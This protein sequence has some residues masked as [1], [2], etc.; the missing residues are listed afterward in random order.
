M[1]WWPRRP[2]RA[3]PSSASSRSG[4]R[5]SGAARRSTPP[6][7]RRCRT[8]ST[9]TWSAATAP[10]NVGLLTG[11]SSINS[12]APVVVMTTEVLRNM[13][14]AGS[15]TLDN[16][17]FVVMDE[18]HYL[19]D[20][21][22]GAV[23]EEV[24]IGLAES[25]QLVA[26]SATVSNAEEF[27]D[28]LSEVRG[29][30]AVVVSERRPVPLFQHVLVG[31]RLYDLF[32]DEAPT[33]VALPSQANAEV[34]PALV[35][36][37]KE[38]SRHVRD[39]SRRPRGRGGKGK[40]TVALRQRRVRRRRAPVPHRGRGR[41]A[42]LAGRGLPGGPGH[43]A[44]RR[45]AAARDRV[46]LLPG[47]LRRRRRSAARL[48]TAADLGRRAGRAGRDRR[49]ARRRTVGGRPAGAGLRQVRRGAAARDRRAPRRD[50]AR[51]QGGGRGGLREGPGQ[52]GLRHRDAGPG[53]QH[54]GPQR[55][56]GEAGQVQ[57]RD[58]RRHHAGGVHPADR[59]G[60]APWHRRRGSR[61]R[62][63]AAGAG[64][65]GGGRSGLAPDVPAE[66]LV[67]ADLQ[68]GGQPGRGGRPGPG[69]V[70]AGAV[71]RP[72]PDRP[73]GGGAVPV[74]G[75]QHRGD[76]RAV[77]RGGLRPRATTRRTPGCGPR[78]APSRRRR[79]AS[80]APIAGP[81][82]RRSCSP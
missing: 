5:C 76:R 1:S 82:P 27:G 47:R 36:V 34:N 42:A 14:Y 45:G 40:R 32:A 67:R 11:D 10:A 71:V 24:I 58:P 46:H 39:D 18:V 77:G 62:G 23:W 72:V 80:A 9:P 81:R 4:W 70:A 69:P 59:S 57:R 60:R 7:S 75:P 31:K 65:A 78:S 33:A 41:S 2:G 66:E 28:W 13:I 49:P 56:A 12:E 79:A 21:F 17:G 3:R 43:G 22:R 19:A 15:A 37:S 44:G 74:A 68:H 6:R 30:M 53:H 73:L 29:E 8:R 54:A 25:I 64:S 52:G 26:L 51:L 48:R 20:R 35:K 55:G 38:E 16:L 50:A 63:V 61:R